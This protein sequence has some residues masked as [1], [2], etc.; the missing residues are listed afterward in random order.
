MSNSQK[1]LAAF[2][3]TR[4]QSEKITQ[5]LEPEDFGL[6][7]IEET[8]PAKWHLAHTSWFFETFLLKPYFNNYRTFHPQFEEVFNSYYNQVGRP[9]D[10]SKRGLLSR[11]YV[12]EIFEYRKHVTEHV[13]ELVGQQFNE[14]IAFRLELGTQH[15]MQHQELFF[16]DLKYNFYQNPL[17]PAYLLEPTEK[18]ASTSPKRKP[19]WLNLGEELIECGVDVSKGEFHFDNETPFHPVWLQPYSI[20][21]ALVTNAEYLEFIDDDGYRRSELWLSDGWTHIQTEAVESPL[22][23]ESNRDDWSYFTLGGMQPL[24]MSEPVCHLSY[25]EA[26]A[27]ARWR[28]CRLPTEFEWENASK[29]LAVHGNFM[30]SGRFQPSAVGGISRSYQLFG[31]VWEWSSSAYN[32]YPGFKPNPGAI[33]EYNGKFMSNQFVLRGG[34]CVTPTAQVRPT[35]RNFFP[36]DARWQFSGLRLAKDA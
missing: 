24:A 17:R 27:F 23:W 34:S 30:E 16:T 31:D 14:E 6:Q 3:Q 13:V 2:I 1:L 18:V 5:P 32:A 12:K 22:Y 20:N 11:P 28:Q 21:S 4:T 35:Y 15:E 26:D 25:Y 9:F 10:R 36:A 8:S 19:E 33:G 7:A 29:N